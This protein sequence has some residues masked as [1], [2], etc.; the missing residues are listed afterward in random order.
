MKDINQPII[1][2]NNITKSYKSSGRT[3]L[4]LEELSYNFENGSKTAILGPSGCGKSTLLN[5]LGGIDSEFEGQLLYKGVPIEDFDQFRREH[6]SFIFQ[7][8]NLIGHHNLVKN[9]SIGL[10]NDVINKE[11]V[12]ID[13]LNQVGLGDHIHKKPHQLSGGEQQRVAIARAL[14]RNTDIL[15]CDEPTG[16]LDQETKTEIMSLI[17]EVF[18]EKTVI[19]I[20]HDESLSE[21]YADIILAI[22]DKKITEKQNNFSSNKQLKNKEDQVSYKSFKGRF[23]VNLLSKKLS[24]FNA[25]Y[26]LIIIASIF[27]FGT[28]IVQGVENEVDNYLYDKYE[29]DIIRITTGG[30]TANGFQVN[31]DEY[32]EAHPTNIQGYITGFYTDISYPVYEQ[33]QD[34]FLNMIQTAVISNLADDVIVGR[35]PQSNNEI[36]FSKGA[37]LKNIYLYQSQNED[38]QIILDRLVTLSDEEIFSTLLEQDITLHK[39]CIYNDEKGYRNDLIIVGLIDDYLY[40]NTHDETD[41]LRNAKR[42]GYTY[43]EQFTDDLLFNNNIYMLEEEFLD[44][45]VDVY[46]AFNSVKL[47]NFYIFIEEEN[48]D[49]RNEVFDSLLLF[50]PLFYG[51]GFI[52]EERDVYYKDMYGYKVAILSGCAVLSIFAIVSLFSGLKN[53]IVAHKKNIGIYKS[54]GY[55]TRNIKWM[56]FK[57]GLIIVLFIIVSSLISWFIINSIMSQPMIHALDPNRLLELNH[58]I[59]LNIHALLGVIATVLFITLFTINQALKKVNIIH[60]LRQ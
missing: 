12:A 27:L 20:T 55:T 31:V 58:M 60:L 49:L 57:E 16:S 1:S 2:L 4:V 22:E 48:L 42:Y 59:H 39:N 34:A 32:N 45:I 50:K 19:F 21:D 25:S 14:A 30:F 23:E 24:I 44:Y 15:L 3:E 6:I 28:G 51:R 18:K 38:E 29:T 9:I 47:S 7:E 37:A 8:L 46:L 54:L 26:L 41:D 13:L 36:L 10:T 5:L 52:I 40:Y 11:Q 43:N 56:F 53:N 17:M 33:R 35:M